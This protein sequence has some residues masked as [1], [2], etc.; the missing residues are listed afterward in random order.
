MLTASLPH[1]QQGLPENAYTA[2]EHNVGVGLHGDHVG[3]EKVAAEALLAGKIDASFMLDANHDN[4]SKQGLFGKDGK[5]VRVLASTAKFDRARCN[6]SSCL[7]TLS[8]CRL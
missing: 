6:L 5:D 7:L 1:D 2:V 8:A 3:G 4:F